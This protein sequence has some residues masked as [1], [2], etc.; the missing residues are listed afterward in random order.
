MA[1]DTQDTFESDFAEYVAECDEHLVTARQLLLSAETMPERIDPGQINELFRNFH[2]I[3]GLSGMVSLREAEDLAHQVENYLGAIR[4]H[5]TALSPEGVDLVLA[6]VQRVEELIAARRDG[7]ALPKVEDLVAGIA[8][9][10]PSAKESDVDTQPIQPEAA[11][12]LPAAKLAQIE[13]A[14]SQGSRAW[15]VT[16]APSADLANRGVTVNTVRERLSAA[17]EIIHAEPTV[18]PSGGIRFHFLVASKEPEFERLAMSEGVNLAS[19]SLPVSPDALAPDSQRPTSPL[20][21]ASLVRVSLDRLDDVMRTVGDLVITRS[22]LQTTLAQIQRYV[23]ARDA[24]DL[25][26]TAN[27]MERQL[28]DLRDGVMRVRLVPVRDVFARMRLVV[29]E[30]ARTSGKQIALDFAGEETEVD[31]FIVERLSDPL[32]HLV[33]NAVSHGLELPDER[34][35]AGKT[36]KCRLSL[37]AS[38]AGGVMTIEVE[39]DGRGVD[40]ERVVTQARAT[41]LVATNETNDAAALLDLIC[42]PGLSTRATADRESGRGVGM[43]VVRRSIEDLGG[44]LAMSTQKGEGTRF[45][46]RLP[47]TLAI[48][49]ALIIEVADHTFAVPQS[50]VRQVILVSDEAVTVLE[51]NE[52]VRHSG[53]VLPLLRLADLFGL[54]NPKSPFPALL[55]GEGTQAV[56]LGAGRMVGLREVVVRRLA[57]PLVQVPGLAG[58]TELGD[59]RAVLILDAAGLARYARTRRRTIEQPGARA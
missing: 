23:P 46:V 1:K 42:T 29:R 12:T 53:V 26:E 48:T 36:P 58:A 17:G 59:G 6:S 39:D 11:T 32:L 43:D 41:G 9:L 16:F 2:T 47:L 57:D 54:A 7:N 37:R 30:L 5:E 21:Q 20:S 49:D 56:A 13:A 10:I 52:L 34:V 33:R 22:R 51:N 3:K 28:R 18:L 44:T 25:E 8:K 15:S 31:K 40:T 24:R 14:I 55:V 19:Y 50:A 38:A 27:A 4:K 35:A 45:T